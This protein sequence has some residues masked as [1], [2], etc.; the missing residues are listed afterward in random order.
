MATLCQSLRKAILAFAF[1][2]G[3]QPGVHHGVKSQVGY[4]T[5]GAGVK[6]PF[7]HTHPL[8]LQKGLPIRAPHPGK[9]QVTKT[10]GQ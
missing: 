10:C 6:E 1:H 9:I 3:C 4:P 8:D 5:Q 7:G 2:L